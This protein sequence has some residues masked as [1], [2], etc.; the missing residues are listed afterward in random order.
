L[1][2]DRVFDLDLLFLA[3]FGNSRRP[4]IRNVS[5]CCVRVVRKWQICIGM[6]ERHYSARKQ[7]VDASEGLEQL[8][9]GSGCIFAA[10]IVKRLPQGKYASL[11]AREIAAAATAAATAAAA[12]ASINGG[13]G[14]RGNR[15]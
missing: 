8:N 3:P 1:F 6:D 7:S 14:S 2:R 12:T 11:T 10:L 4:R 5:K 13:Q 9:A 15:A